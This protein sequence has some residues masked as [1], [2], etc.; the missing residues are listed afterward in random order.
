MTAPLVGPRVGGTLS[1]LSSQLE[2]YPAPTTPLQLSFL[3]LNLQHLSLARLILVTDNML[4]S[5][6]TCD[7]V[8]LPHFSYIYG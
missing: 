2:T 5:D 1:F 6:F 7:L 4:T 3:L 8:L